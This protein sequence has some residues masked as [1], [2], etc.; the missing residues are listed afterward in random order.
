MT[1]QTPNKRKGQ[2]GNI[3]QVRTTDEQKR[4]LT[5]EARSRGL[6]L[7]SYLLS[8]ALAAATGRKA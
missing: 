4:T 2:K 6:S 8:V 3:V 7:S 5:T 1:E